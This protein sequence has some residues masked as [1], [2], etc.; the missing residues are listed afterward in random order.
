[1]RPHGSAYEAD[2]A[3]NPSRQPCPSPTTCHRSH[4]SQ[5]SQVWQRCVNTPHRL[6]LL[7]NAV[8][9]LLQRQHP[10]PLVYPCRR[11]VHGTQIAKQAQA[12]SR[13]NA[14]QPERGQGPDLNLQQPCMLAS[15]CMQVHRPSVRP[16]D[17]PNPAP[18]LQGRHTHRGRSSLTVHTAWLESVP[19]C[20]PTGF[21]G[22][23]FT[24]G[25]GIHMQELR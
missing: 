1:M 16:A 6:P 18:P 17:R 3:P 4:A 9:V 25:R 7:R 14:T 15:M 22:T 8:Q 24:V 23:A 20:M 2:S 5:A 11:D 21:L 10:Q 19:W 13:G 12:A